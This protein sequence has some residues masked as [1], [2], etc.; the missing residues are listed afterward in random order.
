[1][2]HKNIKTIENLEQELSR[3]REEIER[4]KKESLDTADVNEQKEKIISEALKSHIKE[5]PPDALHEN[6]RLK[7]EEIEKHIKT[8]EPEDDDRK[9]E[10]LM[11]L[12]REKGV[13]NAVRVCE[14]LKNPHL[15]D[16]LHRR[17]VHYINFE[18]K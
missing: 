6:Y 13:I 11:R 7:K 2:E 12:V 5:N 9:V 15:L 3:I 17:L 4:R 14:S 16:D 1:M 10:E 18:T 8:L